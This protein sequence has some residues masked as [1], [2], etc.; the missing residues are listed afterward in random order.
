MNEITS[1]KESDF[2]NDCNLMN[3]WLQSLQHKPQLRTI[4]LDNKQKGDKLFTL[5]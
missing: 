3:L 4:A 5:K 1:C 2:S